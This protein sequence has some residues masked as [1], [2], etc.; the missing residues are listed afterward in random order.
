[1]NTRAQDTLL[2][3][4]RKIDKVDSD[5]INLLVERKRI[6]SKIGILKQNYNIPVHQRNRETIIFEERIKKAV[7]KGLDANF[8]RKLFKLII[9]RAKT[10]QIRLKIQKRLLTNK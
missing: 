1:M 8:I 4:R 10:E 7:K 3:L 6:I 5:I 9:S 2:N